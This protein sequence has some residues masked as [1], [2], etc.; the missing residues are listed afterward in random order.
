MEWIILC[1]L[2][3]VVFLVLA[4]W[5]ELKINMLA[6]MFAIIMAIITD[7]YNTAIHHRYMIHNAV[8]SILGSSLF[9]LIGPVFVIGTL[10]AQYHPKKRGMTLLNV[11]VITGLYSLTEYTLVYCGVVEYIDWDYFGSLMVNIGAM[12]IIS[13]FSIIILNKGRG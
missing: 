5:K 11:F 3:W 6:G 13:W 1:I 2:N 4:D 9:F 7:F 8:I 10:I 12:T